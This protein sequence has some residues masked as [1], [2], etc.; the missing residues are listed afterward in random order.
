[1]RAVG[2]G[3]IPDGK[4]EILI[5][6]LMLDLGLKPQDCGKFLKQPEVKRVMKF[7]R[8]R[9]E[10]KMPRQIKTGDHLAEYITDT[11][12]ENLRAVRSVF[13]EDHITTHGRHVANVVEQEFIVP[14]SLSANTALCIPLMRDPMG[15][16]L[17]S[18]EPRKLPIPNRLGT[19]D[20]MMHVPSFSLPGT[21]KTVEQARFF[22]AKQLECD[23]EDLF[24][25]GPSFFAQPQLSAER[26]Y[27]F[28]LNAAPNDGRWMR[29][30]RPRGAVNKL[31]C[32]QVEKTT[33]YIEMKALRDLGEWYTGFTPDISNHKQMTQKADAATT[34]FA[35]Q[36]APFVSQHPMIA[37]KFE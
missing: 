16:F 1:L 22:L 25:L 36:L 4:L 8:D 11:P 18:G 19:V 31:V 21:V 35:E 5:G 24:T 7:N 28:A 34:G 14:Q 20:P 32:P 17:I 30:F 10:A 13:V 6:Q 29:W 15:K 12:A 26:I 23:P 37:P 3:L 27:P 2:S 9:R 33:A